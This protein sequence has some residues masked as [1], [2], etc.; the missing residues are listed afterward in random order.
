VWSRGVIGPYFFEDEDGKA[1]TITSQRYTE[2]INEF[3]SLNLPPNNGTLWFQQDGA[4]T[5]TAVISITALRCLFLQRVISRFGD[6][7]W[8]PRSLDLSAPDFFLWGY[9]KSKVYSNHPTDLHALKE[10]IREEIAKLSEETLQAVR[11]SFLT[12]VHLCFEEGGGHLKD[13]VHKK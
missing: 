5:H 7:P 2:M 12:R 3:L 10:N 13:I 6:V 4:T 1:I 11:H 8:P 9:L